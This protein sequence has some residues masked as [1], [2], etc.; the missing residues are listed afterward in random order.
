VLRIPRSWIPKT[1]KLAKNINRGINNF[2][3]AHTV[4]VGK[5]R[6]DAARPSP[7]SSFFAAGSSLPVFATPRADS[8]KATTLCEPLSCSLFYNLA[9]SV[10]SWDSPVLYTQ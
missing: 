1:G 7:L 8:A 10:L 9:H 2:I 6:R 4:L 5:H 3:E